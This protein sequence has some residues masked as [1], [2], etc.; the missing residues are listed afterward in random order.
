MRG[1]CHFVCFVQ[2]FGYLV[3]QQRAL[4]VQSACLLVP[5]LKDCTLLCPG[6]LMFNDSILVKLRMYIIAYGDTFNF[7]FV[8][9]VRYLGIDYF[10]AIIVNSGHGRCHLT[11]WDLWTYG[12]CMIFVNLTSVGGGG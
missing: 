6:L 5:C 8:V 11:F 10:Y 12:L 4:I 3:L 2:S 7:L 1:K 9:T